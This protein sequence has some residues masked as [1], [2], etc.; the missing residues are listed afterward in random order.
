[1][2]IQGMDAFLAKLKAAKA[3]VVT[4]ASRGMYQW[5]ESVM[6]ESKLIVPVSPHGGTLMNTG[7]VMLP[8]VTGKQIIVE[9]G[10]GDEAVDYALAVHEMIGDSPGS[11]DGVKH[12]IAPHPINWTRPGSGPKYL[13]RPF[14][15][16]QKEAVPMIT[17][18]I[19]AE[20]DN[21]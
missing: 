5:A 3:T 4:G 17:A 16:K 2:P 20:F 14:M 18:E 10:Y 13:E 9:M 8:V 6:T 12:P 21:L 1:M 15:Q 19:Q 11:K 7:K